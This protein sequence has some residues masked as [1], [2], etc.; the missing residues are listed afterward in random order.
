MREAKFNF[1]PFL[2]VNALN[3]K[4]IDKTVTVNLKTGCVSFSKP[5]IME[6]GLDGTMILFFV[7]V[8]KKALGWRKI[9]GEGLAGMKGA[10]KVTIYK[11]TTGTTCQIA[12]KQILKAFG[13]KELKS[14]KKMPIET[15]KSN[16][17]D[18]IVDYVI[19]K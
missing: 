16:P 1:V 12:C 14:F 15:Y 11:T 9:E 19:L 10:K 13:F 8:A 7:D 2:Q 17:L 4:V 3:A 18:G 6:K 5:Y